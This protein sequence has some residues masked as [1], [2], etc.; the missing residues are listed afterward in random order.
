MDAVYY[1][2]ME[3]RIAASDFPREAVDII[4]WTFDEKNI[5]IKGEVKENVASI[6]AIIEWENGDFITGSLSGIIRIW[7]MAQ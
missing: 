3:G 7:H 6:R 4:Q 5:L 1:T 2:S